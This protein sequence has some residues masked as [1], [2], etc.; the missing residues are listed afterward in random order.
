ILLGIIFRKNQ[1]IQISQFIM[2]FLLI[3]P[4]F[5]VFELITN[6]NGTLMNSF[7]INPFF[8]STV[9]PIK[10]I[11]AKITFLEFVSTLL[12]TIFSCIVIIEIT[13]KLLIK[14]LFKVD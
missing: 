2:T 4:M 5:F 1:E 7:S 8:T 11:L 6:P 9:S 12:I 13:N 10:L 14:T 3:V